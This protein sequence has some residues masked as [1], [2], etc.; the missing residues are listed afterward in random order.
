MKLI[1]FVQTKSFEKSGFGFALGQGGSWWCHRYVLVDECSMMAE[2]L[3]QID[4]RDCG[5]RTG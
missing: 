4:G 3:L 2:A 1:S 5:T